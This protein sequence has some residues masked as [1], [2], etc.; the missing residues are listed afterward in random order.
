MISNQS[1][2][3]RKNGERERGRQRERKRER[4]R[5]TESERRRRRKE[6][7]AITLCVSTL[8]SVSV[9]TSQHLPHTM[10]SLLWTSWLL[11]QKIL[12]PLLII[13][14]FL[15]IIIIIIFW[16]LVV[17]K[18]NCTCSSINTIT[19]NLLRYEHQISHIV[20]TKTHPKIIQQIIP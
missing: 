4:K 1:V 19:W 14:K 13:A 8:L 17:D 11:W 15:E 16:N 20:N 2:N 3:S 9:P 7:T 5:E 6:K 10:P 12:S 18:C